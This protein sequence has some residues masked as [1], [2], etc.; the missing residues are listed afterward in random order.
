[1]RV[2]YEPDLL[3]E[4]N[5]SLAAWRATVPARQR[6]QVI[7]LALN[8]IR[9]CGAVG[10]NLLVDAGT[11]DLRLNHGRL[12]YLRPALE[13]AR[14]HQLTNFFTVRVLLNLLD[15]EPDW[16]DICKNFGANF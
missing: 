4:L 8:L 7:L 6:R 11:R 9:S 3:A 16:R 15:P 1:V 10:L 14:A 12:E 5:V 13:C 2:D